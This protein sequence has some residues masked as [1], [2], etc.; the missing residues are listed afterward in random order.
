ME[1]KTKQ[2]LNR[3]EFIK[4][5][6]SAA[7]AAPL[8]ISAFKES[9][10]EK[11]VNLTCN[12]IINHFKEIGTWVDWTRTADTVKAGDPSKPVRKMAVAW[13]ASWDAMKREVSKG[14]DMF[15]SHE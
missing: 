3:R 15:I 12:D 13:K 1:T 4:F 14:A 7:F 11:M 10:Y 8:F 6:S 9:K 2:E 5:S